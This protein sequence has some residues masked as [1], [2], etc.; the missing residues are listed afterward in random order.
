MPKI[1]IFRGFIMSRPRSLTTLDPK[2]DFANTLSIIFPRESLELIDL[3]GQ[4]VE[5]A[6]DIVT[7]VIT[8]ASG[9]TWDRLRIVTGRGNH[10]N[11]KGERGT[12]YNSFKEWFEAVRTNN[13]R[14]E[15]FDGYYEVVIYKNIPLRDP[16]YAFMK[17]NLSSMLTSSID[18]LKANASKGDLS[19]LIELSIRYDRGHGVQKDY[20]KSTSCL[21]KI[22]D[23]G[24]VY[25]EY[26]IGVRYFIGKGIKQ[27]N[28]EAIRYL[29]LSADK[30]Y[31]QSAFVLADIYRHGNTG[32][33][34]PVLAHKYY[35]IAAEAKHHPESSRRVGD[36]FND[37][38]ACGGRNLDL[39]IQWLK[40][41]V[42]GGDAPAAF[43]LFFIYKSSDPAL[44][45]HYLSISAKLGEPDAQLFYG[46]HLFFGLLG[47][48]KDMKEGIVWLIESGKQDQPYA[49]FVL[50][51]LT[52]RH[53]SDLAIKY[54]I[55]AAEA[56]SIDAQ[57]NILF[58]SE[59]I[60]KAVLEADSKKEKT[61]VLFTK[62][63]QDK[64]KKLFLEQDNET[65]L[66]LYDLSIKD[67]I[68][69]MMQDE[70]DAGYVNKAYSL[71]KIMAKKRFTWAIYNYS[72][73]NLHG[74]GSIIKI[75]SK[76][77]YTQLQHGERL[78]D[79]DCLALLG[80]YWVH[81]LGV[82][83]PEN[84]RVNVEKGL[85]YYARATEKNNPLAHSDLG[86][87]YSSSSFPKSIEHY[88][89]AMQHSMPNQPAI[90]AQIGLY[91]NSAT[92]LGLIYEAGGRGIRADI[93]KALAYFKLAASHGSSD[94]KR[95]LNSP[96]RMSRMKVNPEAIA[97]I[98]SWENLQTWEHLQAHASSIP[99][100][101]T[102]VKSE[103]E[104]MKN[105]TELAASGDEFSQDTLA[106]LK[107]A[108]DFKHL[109]STETK[110]IPA[111]TKKIAVELGSAVKK[112]QA[113]S[114]KPSSLPVT[115]L[116]Q[117]ST[118]IVQTPAK[119]EAEAKS[120]II[121]D[122]SY[123]IGNKQR[124]KDTPTIVE[125]KTQS[126]LPFFA[127]KNTAGKVDAVVVI[128]QET[129]FALLKQL[130]TTLHYPGK[131][132]KSSKYKYFVFEGLTLPSSNDKPRP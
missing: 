4:S 62:D 68:I 30:G 87:F 91:E 94:A 60:K 21:L 43:S 26:E 33:A 58:N 102:K 108:P 19:S 36:S 63:L 53:N 25:V 5:K 67:I 128:N 39:A 112:P 82:H 122:K 61:I 77:A 48:K 129:D 44:A 72:S 85:S 54:L 52:L 64:I 2:V 13:M 131:F 42:E 114:A 10:V 12:I 117:Q 79:G 92:Q 105:L 16:V 111:E 20:K 41:A 9:S 127:L 88:E 27:N 11:S 23:C 69:D 120:T 70:D 101:P 46:L 84:E 75:N 71:L 15:E 49:L 51:R 14:L 28:A 50:S 104:F 7:S 97:M 76:L 74:V 47:I 78:G 132:F 56:G 38:S 89:K 123:S 107:K 130:Q 125:L 24:D 121:Y 34:D 106:M 1:P 8:N 17:E 118:P 103:A 59:S 99:A 119:H 45:L 109:F 96:Q 83:L 65:L 100:D 31:I 93:Y 66:K 113:P 115:E 98:K 32:K 18:E 124:V 35:L 29:T 6:K 55:S 37:G 126:S 116:K 95:I 73:S 3:H 90:S 22:K 86:N 80:R 40:I 57:C 81:G 110:T